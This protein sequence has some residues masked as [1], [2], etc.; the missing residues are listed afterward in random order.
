[1]VQVIG[2]GKVGYVQIDIP[3]PV[4][5]SPEDRPGAVPGVD[6]C[7]C[8]DIGEGAIAIIMVQDIWL[9]AVAQVK[10]KVTV[11]IEITPGTHIGR[12]NMRNACLRC[13]FR[14]L[15]VA[16]SPVKQIGRIVA[17]DVNIIGPIPIVIAKGNAKVPA[18]MPNAGTG[19]PIKEKRL[20]GQQPCHQS[21]QQ[22]T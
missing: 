11:I 8:A 6:A 4:H 5:I 13:H 22:K 9:I 3:I 20:C 10:I 14:K 1:M 19:G 18:G 17:G 12:P 16:D 21:K 7:T 15:P 2:R